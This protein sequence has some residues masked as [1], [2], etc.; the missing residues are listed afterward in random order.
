MGV[1]SPEFQSNISYF[2]D[3]LCLTVDSSFIG[4][5]S[6]SCGDFMIVEIVGPYMCLLQDN[7]LV[8]L[9]LSLDT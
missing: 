1:F 9:D 6:N 2:D 7:C 3:I 5:F 8:L 4:Q